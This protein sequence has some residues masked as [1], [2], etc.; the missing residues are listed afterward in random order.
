MRERTFCRENAVDPPQPVPD[1]RHRPCDGHPET[2]VR[3]HC[4]EIVSER[5]LAIGSS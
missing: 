2:R 4:G 1:G 5:R 3:E